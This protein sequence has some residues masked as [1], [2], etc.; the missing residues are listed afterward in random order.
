MLIY[1][2]PVEAPNGIFVRA[3]PTVDSYKILF[4]VFPQ[5]DMYQ[6]MHCTVMYSEKANP[7]AYLPIISKDTRYD[8][9]ADHLEH[10]PGHDGQGYVVLVLDSPD[11]QKLHKM[12]RDQGFEPTF[13]EYK[14]HVSLIHPCPKKPEN[15]DELNAKL[16]ANPPMLTF[17]YGGYVLNDPKDDT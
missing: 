9:K 14:P 11:L 12:F 17:C 16:K 15:L 2:A 5:T 6:D 13:P 10:W 1:E 8:A 4:H 3:N 7:R